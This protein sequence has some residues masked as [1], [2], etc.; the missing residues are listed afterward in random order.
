MMAIPTA[1]PTAVAALTLDFDIDDMNYMGSLALTVV[2]FFTS[3]YGIL[4]YGLVI[5]LVMMV[6]RWVYQFVVDRP[7]RGKKWVDVVYDSH[8]YNEFAA[9][10][11]YMASDYD[12]VDQFYED[13]AENAKM[14]RALDRQNAR[15]RGRI[16]Q[17]YRTKRRKA[18]GLF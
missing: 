16:N 8:Q 13:P 2:N 14:R 7:I 12:L 6:I 18:K 3:Q 1:N 15:A 11:D 4:A 10:D 5:L 9:M 17:K